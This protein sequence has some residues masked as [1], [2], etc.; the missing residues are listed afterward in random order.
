MQKSH[1]INYRMIETENNVM[2]PS[3]SIS[4]RT[5]KKKKIVNIDHFHLKVSLY[6]L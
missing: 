2:V 1:R 3:N 6:Q 5:K 4:L